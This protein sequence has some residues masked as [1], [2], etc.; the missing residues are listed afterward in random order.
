MPEVQLGH[1]SVLRLVQTASTLL[2]S[3]HS[4][5][6]RYGGILRVEAKINFLLE[7]LYKYHSTCM[8]KNPNQTTAHLSKPKSE[9]SIAK[10]YG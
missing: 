2:M 6:S 7:I 3:K 9:F 10:M 4:L 5:P 1:F 8:L